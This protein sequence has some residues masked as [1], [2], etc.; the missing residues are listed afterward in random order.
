M[1]LHDWYDQFVD[2]PAL[3]SPRALLLQEI[4][5]P[6]V[7]ASPP[8]TGRD[9]VCYTAAIS[10]GGRTSAGNPAI[11]HQQCLGPGSAPT[12]DSA[13]DSAS[14]SAS[15]SA[16]I[17]ASAA[18]SRVAA[19]LQFLR[20][21]APGAVVIPVYQ[22]TDHAHHVRTRFSDLAVFAWWRRQLRPPKRRAHGQ[23]G[24]LRD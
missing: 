11:S 10:Y 2:P 9:S 22:D 19:P 3:P 23:D 17:T 1:N 7:P 21:E 20:V 13:A 6:P 15:S 5:Q 18:E 24:R 4:Q 16:T 12:A 14:T 8:S